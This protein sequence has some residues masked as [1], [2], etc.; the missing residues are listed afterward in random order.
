MKNGIQKEIVNN[1]TVKYLGIAFDTE[2]KFR[3]HISNCINKGNRVICITRR[4]FLHI[5]NKSFSKLHKTLIRPHFEYGNIIWNPRLKQDIKA[6]ERVQ[7]RATKVVHNV[8][9]L[10]YSD[11][12]EVLKISSPTYR[13]FPG[14]MIQ[15]Y[16][17]LHNLEDIPFTR[18]LELNENPTRGHALKLKKN[19]ARKKYV[20]NFSK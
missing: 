20:R 16:K 6:I 12:L 2:L 10:S 7:I 19:L 17:L 9:N 11:R 5:T 3:K 13:R 15:V 18:F 1:D 14:D 8:R 4:S